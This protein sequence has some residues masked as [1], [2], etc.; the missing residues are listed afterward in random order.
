M[1]EQEPVPIEINGELDLHTFRPN[2]IGDLI[3]DYLRECRQRGILTVRVIH[4]KGTG[5]LRT[6]VHSV[7]ERLEMVESFTWPAAAHY[8][9]WGAT[10]AHLKPVTPGSPA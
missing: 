2:E 5:A 1:D 8:G 7:L 3:P 4:G 9:G 6:S 10:W